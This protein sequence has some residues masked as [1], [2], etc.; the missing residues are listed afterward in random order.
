MF[1][2]E[3]LGHYLQ[4][5]NENSGTGPRSLL[6]R[7]GIARLK[8]ASGF[9]MFRLLFGFIVLL[10]YGWPFGVCQYRMTYPFPLGQSFPSKPWPD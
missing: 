6:A 5:Q 1:H 7:R 3:A 10:R 2:L 4:G 8:L 9:S